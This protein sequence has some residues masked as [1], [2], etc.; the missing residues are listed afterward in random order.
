MV[1]SNQILSFIYTNSDDHSHSEEVAQY[2]IPSL[3]KKWSDIVIKISSTNITLYLNCHKIAARNITRNPQELVFDTAST[4][5]IA[6]AGPHVREKF[7]V[8]TS[9]KF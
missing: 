9:E 5:Y 1:E 4:L 7:N 6:Q 2:T 8:S 3:Y